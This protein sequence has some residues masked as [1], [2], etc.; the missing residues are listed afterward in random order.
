MSI[1]DILLDRPDMRVDLVNRELSTQ[2][3]EYSEFGYKGAL[4][5]KQHQK[6][7]RLVVARAVE[8]AKRDNQ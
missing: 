2:I 1:T 6:A 5:Q 7:M 3:P 4:G 8:E